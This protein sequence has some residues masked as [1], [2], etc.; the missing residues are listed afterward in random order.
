MAE[1][2]AEAIDR[3]I[4]TFYSAFDNRDG[5]MPN[6]DNLRDLFTD[7]ARIFRSSPAGLDGWSVEAFIAPRIAWLTDGTLTD[8]HEWETESRTD[9]EGR[10]ASR[11]SL[12]RKSGRRGEECLDGQGRKFIQLVRKDAQWLI[13][14]IVW[15]D[16]P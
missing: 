5:A 6:G 4:A 9:I 3:R 7:D 10:I 14:S 15:E 11:R 1:E 16:L 8:F 13:A 2:D 12:Y